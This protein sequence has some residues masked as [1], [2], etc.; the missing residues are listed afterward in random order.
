[1]TSTVLLTLIILF[2]LHWVADFFLQ[3]DW[4]AVNKS[5]SN[6]ALGAHI[7]VYTA[8][9]LIATLNPVFAIVN[10]LIHGAIDYVTSRISSKFHKAG[11]IHN[12]FVVIGFDQF[13]HIVTLLV[14]YYF[15]W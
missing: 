15:L 13:L 11:D 7:G 4:M 12:F 9:M 6:K 1:M 5:K 2:A 3:S 14:T 8:V 10:G